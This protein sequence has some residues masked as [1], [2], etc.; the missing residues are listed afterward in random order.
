[1]E[2]Y[3]KKQ[4]KIK[5]DGREFPLA[6]PM[7]AYR[8]MSNSIEGFDFGDVNKMVADPNKM[9]PALFI[10]AKYGAILN[11]QKV[12][13]DQDWIDLHTPVSTRKIIAIQL[14][15]IN[16]ISEN[17]DMESEEDEDLEREVDLVLQEIQKKSE[18]IN[19][20]GGKSQP[21]D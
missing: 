8:E 5:I 3:T 17:M 16:T 2:S 14:A 18:R 21:G 10:L 1:M 4:Y 11:G 12:D 15:I 7:K 20:P 9:M 13:F 19:S 6:F